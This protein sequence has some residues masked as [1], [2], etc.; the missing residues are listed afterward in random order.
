MDSKPLKIPM[1]S[2]GA[3]KYFGT[4]WSIM[5]PADDYTCQNRLIIV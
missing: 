1:V 5:S 4:V 2:E 3:E